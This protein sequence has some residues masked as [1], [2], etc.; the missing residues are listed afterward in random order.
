LILVVR[1]ER[2]PEF[3][4][5]GQRFGFRKPVRFVDGGRERQDSVWNGL[6]AL[7]A[8]TELVAIHDGARPCTPRE[9]VER[10]IERA[11]LTGAAVAARRVTDTVKESGDGEQ[12]LRTLDRTRLW[13]VQTPQAFRVSVIR[14][15]LAR[16]REA[17]VQVT[18]DTAACEWIGQAV[19]LVES[20]ALNPKVTVASDVA[21]VSALLDP[22]L[23]RLGGCRLV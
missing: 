23:A 3:E 15:A 11:R 20:G 4:S 18:D 10:T 8:T 14:E 16:V 6:L 7:D 17:G 9:L 21:L 5:L 2:R 22:A 19:S 1:A 12:V 13:T